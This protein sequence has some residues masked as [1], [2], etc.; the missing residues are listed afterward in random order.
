MK[1]PLRLWPALIGL[2]GFL[3]VAADV[4]FTTTTIEAGEFAPNTCWY[5]MAIGSSNLIISDNGSADYIALDRVRTELDDADLWCFVGD[6]SNGFTIYNKQAGTGKVL[7]SPA[8]MSGQ[9]GGTAYVRLKN[10]ADITSADRT[11]WSFSASTDLGKDVEAYY[12]NQTGTPANKVNNR[13]NR[14][15]FWTAGADHG[16]S[17]VIQLAKA[18][19]TVSMESGEF[20][21]WNQSHTFASN[22]A[23]SVIEGLTLNA[24]VNN[25]EANGQDLT[26]YC[27]ANGNKY[28]LTAPTGYYIAEY[29]FTFSNSCGQAVDITPADGEAVRCENNTTA[30]VHINELTEQTA[31][32]ALN[33]TDN[34]NNAKVTLKDFT[35]ELVRSQAPVEPSYDVFK[36]M[37][38]QTPYRIPAIS[39]AHN[40]DLIAISDYRYC[41]ADIGYGHIDLQARLS[42]DNGKT[43][44]EIITVAD[45][46]GVAGSH[47]DGYGDAALVA[48]SESDTVLVICAAGNVTYAGSNRTNPIRVA[49]VYSYDNGKTWQKPV[50]ITEDIYGLFD[51][52][53]NGKVQSLFFGS[54]RICQSRS[55]K[56]GNFYRLYAALCARGGNRVIYSD[57]FG[58]TW[59]VLGDI[60]TSPAPSGD[61]PK[62]EE[63]PDGSV[64]LSSRKYNGRYYNIFTFSNAEKAQGSWSDAVATD[65]C[66]NG[67]TVLNNATN[68]EILIVPARRRSDNTPVFLVLQ[69]IPFG[70]GRTNVG[71]YYKGLDSYEDFDTP[72]HFSEN[73]EGRYQCSRMG[74]AYST[75][76][77][78][79][80]HTIGFLYEESTYGADYTIVYKNYSIEQITDSTYS[81]DASVSRGSFLAPQIDA[82]I[83]PALNGTGSVGTVD[84]ARKAEVENALS[85]YKSEPN[86]TTLRTLEETLSSALINMEDGHWYRMVNV[87]DDRRLTLTPNSSYIAGRESNPAT[88]DQLFRFEKQTDGYWNI[89]NGNYGRYVG[90]TG[91]NNARISLVTEKNAGQFYIGTNRGASRIVCATASNETHPCLTLATNTS[92]M[93]G[94]LSDSASLWTIIPVETF[95]VNIP[96]Y[97]YAAI[98]LPFASDLPAGTKA[99]TAESE[100]SGYL[101][102]KAIEATTIPAETPFLLKAEGN[103]TVSLPINPTD[104]QG[105]IES[106]LRGILRSRSVSG[107]VFTLAEQ[108]GQAGM[109]R[110]PAGSGSLDANSAYYLSE[111][112]A[113][114]F[115]VLTDDPTVGI[116]Q[117]TTQEATTTY[118]DLS[119]RRVNSPVHGIY[120][121]GKGRKVVLK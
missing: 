81:Y 63:L 39:K 46:S 100:N 86:D 89:V 62:C 116:K 85:A 72:T 22:W 102:I 13:N 44:G 23:S 99:F 59:H 121:T 96:D 38:G 74:S 15:A 61:E 109:E 31:S 18:T 14:L 110:R 83:A 60:N 51:D 90:S 48:D 21:A 25:M 7:S 42:S 4:P 10:T 101:N 68:G 94:A 43:W 103:T 45:G 114:D 104:E 1:L 41:G 76:T 27:T 77:L 92:I 82:I 120:V 98:N 30:S 115:L 107:N 119:G 95:D 75:M 40:G 57:D 3:N 80:D 24:G 79:A 12:M 11:S 67:I 69:S 6:E 17:L 56:T 20:T 29:R 37:S 55:V 58:L 50:D 93:P 9:N 88:A 112:S 8:T 54:G 16:S 5:T 97:G 111:D 71:I 64:V 108:E 47:D 26:I 118:Y 34:S 32:F 73:W 78:Q 117:A 84:P 53:N 106:L 70:N 65:T 35:V 33:R 91:A 36:T 2:S 66:T 19:A 52:R 28:T 87:S 49:R 113:A 105:P